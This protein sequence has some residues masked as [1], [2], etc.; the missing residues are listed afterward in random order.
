M[1]NNY[2]L[3]SEAIQLKTPQEHAWVAKRLDNRDE[4]EVE[5]FSWKIDRED[6]TLWIYAE[7]FGNPEKVAI[8]VMEYLKKFDPTG[9]FTLT[10]A[11]T[12]SKPRVSEFTGGAFFVTAKSMKY[13]SASDWARTE[14]RAWD[15]K[16]KPTPKRKKKTNA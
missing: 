5:A 12:C 2:L 9:C 7:E 16:K 14:R 15:A 10:Y 8:F 6:N 3:F 4:D 11:E 1:A 13:R